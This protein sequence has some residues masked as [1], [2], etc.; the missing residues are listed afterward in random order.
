MAARILRLIPAGSPIRGSAYVRD[1][2]AG[3]G[4]P[5]RVVSGTTGWNLC[6]I[7]NPNRVYVPTT[8]H[9]PEGQATGMGRTS[10]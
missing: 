2:C 9:R 10:S 6:E 4:E 3:C 5:I 1:Y 7:C 8:A